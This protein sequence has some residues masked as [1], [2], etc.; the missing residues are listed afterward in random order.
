MPN[1]TIPLGRME[2]IEME[3][4]RPFDPLEGQGEESALYVVR[5]NYDDSYVSLI[6]ALIIGGLIQSRKTLLLWQEGFSYM[7]CINGDYLKH[8]LDWDVYYLMN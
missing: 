4:D 8:M 5:Q 3:D 7:M 6:S 1:V 2:D